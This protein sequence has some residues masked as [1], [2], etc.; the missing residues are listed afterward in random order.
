MRHK[1]K[2]LA[3]CIAFILPTWLQAQEREIEL[4]YFNHGDSVSFR[5]APADLVTFIKG[6]K[7][8]YTLQRRM[9]GEKEWTVISPLL[10]PVSNERFAILETINPDAA[11]VRELI[12]RNE[13][14]SGKHSRTPGEAAFEYQFLF[15]MA[16]F[17]CDLSLELAKAA[18][19]YFVDKPADKRA[20]YLYRVV[21][22]DG[23]NAGNVREVEV[24]MQVK[25]TLP[26]PD[27]FEAVF[28]P[29]T[30]A[31]TW[32]TQKFK[33]YYSGYRIERSLD[34]IRFEPTQKRPIVHGYSEEKFEYT[35]TYQDSLVNRESTH[36]YRLSGYSPF[37]M[38]GPYSKVVEGKGEPEFSDVVIRMDTVI[39]DKKDRAEIS[40]TMNKAFEKRIK[41]FEVQRTTD[42]KSGFE[43]LNEGLLSPSKRSFRD[44][45]LKRSNYY[46]IVAYGK[47]DGQVAMSDVYYKTR[48]DSIPPAA[49]VGLKGTIDSTGVVRLE[50]QPNTEEDLLGYQVFRSNSGRNNDFFHTTDTI[51]PNTWFIDTLSL[52]TLTNEVYYKVAAFDKNYNPSKQSAAI[53]LEK[54]DTL[55]PVPALFV[56]L[57]QPKEKVE[58][59]WQNSSS[60]DLKRIELYRQIDDSDSLELI[61]EWSVPKLASS[62]ADSYTFS[63]EYVSYIIRSYDRSGNMSE[64]HSFP[65]A[66]KGERPGCIGNLTY[67]VNR[68]DKKQ[69]RL[70]WEKTSDCKINRTVVYRKENDGRMLPVGSVNPNNYFFIDE[71][72]CVGCKYV[73]MI[74]AIAERPSKAV[75]SGEITF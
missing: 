68:A 5:W 2:I 61:K 62:Y 43:T 27:D 6:A 8:G 54:P 44:T 7:Q 50:W 17:A 14:N 33:G 26:T 46:R 10:R 41:G 25:S 53:K 42:F 18:G 70:R 9:T 58:I 48:V 28:N 35:A 31:F 16:L 57:H 15:G 36:Y 29:A 66:T 47:L 19:L 49:P 74:R 34:G 73:Y 32:S 51:F 45:K 38:Y 22:G 64:S 24:N 21:F 12:Y 59:T 56:K 30:V 55:P 23:R 67:D 63:G 20:V 13:L 71:N 11:A 60:S 39:F 52:K 4:L 1:L 69:I 65:L 40:W 75:Y 72:I 37:G 3:I